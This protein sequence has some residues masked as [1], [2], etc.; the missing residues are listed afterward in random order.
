MSAEEEDRL[1]FGEDDDD[2]ESEIS[3]GLGGEEADEGDPAVERAEEEHRQPNVAEQAAETSAAGASSS[4]APAFDQW[5]TDDGRPL[6]EGWIRKVSSSTRET[7]FLNLK[8]RKSTWDEPK[9]PARGTPP[10]AAQGD[11][12]K[13]AS[14]GE[15]AKSAARSNGDGASYASVAAANAPDSAGT[16]EQAARSDA[17]TAMD[18]DKGT[19]ARLPAHRAAQRGF[20]E[21][22]ISLTSVYATPILDL[23][24]LRALISLVG[25]HF[26]VL[27][28]RCNARIQFLCG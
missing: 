7:Y 16:A 27:A 17:D 12:E 19:S 11:G 22:D 10:P 18:E 2:R 21:A 6:P 3:L 15:E 5:S 24:I 8:T 28:A 26:A 20:E 13:P 25:D 23:R 4:A 9:E 1:D 14:I